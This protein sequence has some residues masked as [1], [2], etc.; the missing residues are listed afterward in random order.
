MYFS[1]HLGAPWDV[2]FRDPGDSGSHFVPG[3]LGACVAFWDEVVVRS[4]RR[5]DQLLEFLQDEI[6]GT[7]TESPFYGEKFPGESFPNRIPEKFVDFVQEEVCALQIRSCIIPWGRVR[8][9][10]GPSRPRLFQPLSVETSK[11]RLIFD[12]RPLDSVAT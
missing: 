1:E 12:A 3:G 10:A 7:S 11:P 6:E 4:H 2:A 9:A 5:R 8:T